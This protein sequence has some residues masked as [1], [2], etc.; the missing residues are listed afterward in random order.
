MAATIENLE[1]RIE[2]TSKSAANGVDALSASLSRL[3]SA[4]GGALNSNNK[5]SNS[6]SKIGASLKSATARITGM[7]LGYNK[8][9]D[10]CADAFTESNEYIES[11]NLF[12]VTMGDAADEALRFAETVEDV[13]GIDIA[14]W[15]TNQGVFQRL[16]TGFGISADQATI[17]SKNLTQLGYDL[18]SFFN[19]DIETVVVSPYF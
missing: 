8:L 14:E 1:I 3:R 9:I 11:L 2:A 17:M 19:T 13:M 16:A 12:R 5:L 4:A 7:V 6:F 18:A 10:V 15:I